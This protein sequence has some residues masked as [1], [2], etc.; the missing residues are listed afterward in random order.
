MRQ[1]Y[2][3]I[4]QDFVLILL[5]Q[6]ACD[7]RRIVDLLCKSMTFLISDN[8]FS[9]WSFQRTISNNIL[10]RFL[11]RWLLLSLIWHPPTF[12]HRRQCSIIGRPGLNHRV[13]DG[14]G[15]FPWAH[16]HQKFLIF[17]WRW[18]DSNPWPPACKAGAL[19]T[20]LHPQRFY[21]VGLR[22]LELPTSRLS[23]VRSNRLSYKPIWF[24]SSKPFGSFFSFLS[25]IT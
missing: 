9:V 12:P 7:F 1:D 13:R 15:C 6:N 4:L 19:P 24:K 21:L 18:G 10:F 3:V 16:R 11:L 14:N 5:S 22:R 17:D 25:L 8:F 20:E 2:F 23:G